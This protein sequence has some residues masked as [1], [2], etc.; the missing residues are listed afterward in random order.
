MDKQD[1]KVR[2][3]NFYKDVDKPMLNSLYDDSEVK[4]I[5]MLSTK[6]EF[7]LLQK[8]KNGWNV[9]NKGKL[10]KDIDSIKKKKVKEFTSIVNNYH[11]DN[12]NINELKNTNNKMI[13]ELESI[14]NL[15]K[16]LGNQELYVRLQ[17]L[18]LLN[19]NTTTQ[20]P[21]KS[22]KQNSKDKSLDEHNKLEKIKLN[23]TNTIQ[24]GS[25]KIQDESNNKLIKN[26]ETKINNNKSN[27]KNNLSD[28]SQLSSES[29]EYIE[30]F[31]N[32]IQ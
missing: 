1:F 24:K 8:D 13:S 10:L 30:V 22:I 23:L 31:S 2:I 11:K 9:K 7:P 28:L 14:D 19:N 25:G 26:K 4:D 3:V 27:V 16:S 20:K 5:L 21:S 32:L 6:T 15:K 29:E 18:A 12:T 17:N